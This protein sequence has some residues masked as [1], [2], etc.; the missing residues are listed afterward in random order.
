MGDPGDLFDKASERLRRM[1]VGACRYDTVKNRFRTQAPQ[2]RDFLNPHTGDLVVQSTL[3]NETLADREKR[4]SQVQ[5]I[6]DRNRKLS[7]EVSTFGFVRP[8]KDLAPIEHIPAAT[9]AEAEI[10]ARDKLGVM[11]DFAGNL[12][13]GN[14]IN[15][16]MARLHNLGFE[17]PQQVSLLSPEDFKK[18]FPPREHQELAHVPAAYVPG[19]DR[20]IVQDLPQWDRMEKD[21]QPLHRQNWFSTP[22]ESHLIFHENGHRLHK[23]RLTNK[24]WN[25]L[26]DQKPDEA[27]SAIIKKEVGDYAASDFLEL[28]AEMFA[29][30]VNGKT[31]SPILM[32]HY[33]EK[34]GPLP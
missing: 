34:K 30:M 8:G 20:I 21:L 23:M 1:A 13:V 26:A 11:A 12:Q 27:L 24:Q 32:A 10:F 33:F 14:K 28:I 4:L 6:I 7:R 17:K 19:L 9:A 31:Y 2:L 16:S 15:A 29:G 3:Q 18:H 5:V 22:S 25:R